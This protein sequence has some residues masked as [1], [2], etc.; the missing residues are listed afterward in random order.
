MS[1]SYINVPCGTCRGAKFMMKLGGLYGECN[2]CKGLGEIRKLKKIEP[3]VLKEK[4]QEIADTIKEGMKS[5]TPPSKK[6]E[7]L[8]TNE[9][10]KK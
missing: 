3:E 7:G 1:D 9:K 5:F 6:V 4:A 8:K 2:E 10:R